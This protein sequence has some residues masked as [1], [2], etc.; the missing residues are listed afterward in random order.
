MNLL[1]LTGRNLKIFFRDKASVFFSL[2]SVF[3]IIGLYALFL[4]DV[5]TNSL[6]GYGDGVRFLIDS[7]IMGG[8]LSVTAV[9][10]TMGAFGIMVNDRAQN[11][12]K[13]FSSSPIKRTFL[14]GGYIFSAF[15]IGMIM[16]LAALLLF[17]IYIVASG[18]ALLGFAAVLKVL[19]IML[20]SV[21]AGS[22]AVFFVVSFFKSNNAFAAASTVLGT[23]IGF[24]TGIYIPI[25]SLPEAVQAIIKVFPFSHSAALFRQ[26]VMEAPMN[27]VFA[28][29]PAA[30]VDGFSVNMGV[31]Y[32]FGDTL[33]TA[34]TSIWILAATAA[35][36]FGLATL[37][38]RRK[39]R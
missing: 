31:I 28:G 23:L 15:I 9:T 5:L 30:A 32:Q 25:G 35:V 8:V 1:A 18:G 10:T 22:S 3:I 7:W 38:M 4:G 20:L 27:N 2:L 24:L 37:N 14:A 19:G 13:D 21:M 39:L 29:A 26:A 16:S 6:S 33:T 17:E 36:F 11:I 34:A 12:I